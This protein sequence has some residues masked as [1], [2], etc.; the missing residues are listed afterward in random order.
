MR[1]GTS[2]SVRD[3]IAAVYDFGRTWPSS[4]LPKLVPAAGAPCAYTFV[5]ISSA[6]SAR[7]S[8]NV[9]APM[10]VANAVPLASAAAN[11]E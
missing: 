8:G 2:Y 3:V 11:S 4:T 5:T 7:N 1:T 10:Y 9:A 6:V